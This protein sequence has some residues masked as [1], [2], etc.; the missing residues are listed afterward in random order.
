MKPLSAPFP[1]LRALALAA[2]MTTVPVTAHADIW[3]KIVSDS[4]HTIEIDSS[5]IFNTDRGAKVSWG[6]IVLND[7]EAK[8]AGYRMIKALNRYDCL[9]R[10]FTIIK[11]VYMD[12]RTNILREETVPEP[13]PVTV[14]NNS[15][16]ERI[17]R[18]VC[19]LPTASAN[20]KRDKKA[21]LNAIGQLADAAHQAARNALPPTEPVKEETPPQQPKAILLPTSTEKPVAQ[22]TS[23]T[24]AADPPP[25]PA[26]AAPPAPIVPIAPIQIKP[27]QMPAMPQNPAVPKPP[28][29]PEIPQPQKRPPNT[30]PPPRREPA[31]IQPLILPA[32][33]P[34]TSPRKP[35]SAPTQQPASFSESGE[36][37]AYSGAVEPE[38]WGKLRPEWKAC[39]EGKRQSPI[40]FTTN[41]PVPVDLDPVKF[42]YRPAS[43][44]ITNGSRQLQIRITEGMGMEVR[45]QR[46]LLEGL[47][48]HRPAETRI[49]NKIA[50]MEAHFF[51]RDGKGQIAVLAVQFARSGQPSAP[52]QTLLNNLPLEKGD[53]Y[54]PQATLDMAAFLPTSTAHYLYMGSLT[55]PPCTEGVLWVVMKEP[56]TISD[57]Q[58]EVFSRLHADNARPPQPAFDRLILES[59]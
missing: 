4:G 57:E 34:T 26:P 35:A 58:Y 17:W 25:T 51:H 45:G 43:F 6:R 2:I 24:V 15:V 54:T 8:Q 31:A 30:S 20:G 21:A 22:K 19:G 1:L 49:D 56:M 40:D 47:T 16:D 11:R 14:R 28:A 37:W 10:S 50:D 38:F 9:G 46:Y 48:L 13:R 55:M 5:V 29:L 18:K 32:P 36:G 44:I 12:D 7:S 3:E 53:S 33:A 23:A 59:R 42:D 39:T 52:L 27:L 41:Q